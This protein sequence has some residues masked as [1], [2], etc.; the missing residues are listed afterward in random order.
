M[1]LMLLFGKAI[2]HAPLFCR[3]ACHAKYSRAQGDTF[4]IIKSGHVVCTGAG[5]GSV[6]F[7]DL[8][9]KTGMSLS[10]LDVAAMTR[11]VPGDYFGERAL[12]KAVPR[13]ANVLSIGAVK[14]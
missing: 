10:V 3:R 7:A 8:H 14:A 5:S 2:R 11:F 4:Y 12:L 9:L 1:T 6:V 13:A